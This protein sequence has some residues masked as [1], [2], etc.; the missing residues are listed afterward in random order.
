MNVLLA[1]VVGYVV[2]AR[3]GGKD[4]G[5][6]GRSLKT[7]YDTDEFTDVVVAARA[8]VGSTL[9]AVATLVDGEPDGPDDVPD[10]V[11]RVRR[12]VGQD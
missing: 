10:V 6:L 8:Q 1:L 12:L 5:R 9:R 2:G 3:T 4:L 11:T 7:L